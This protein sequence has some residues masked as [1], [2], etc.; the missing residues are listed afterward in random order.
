[1]GGSRKKVSS[2]YTPFHAV[3]KIQILDFPSHFKNDVLGFK[4]FL[5]ENVLLVYLL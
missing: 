1:M 4:L 3:L 2:P 5:L